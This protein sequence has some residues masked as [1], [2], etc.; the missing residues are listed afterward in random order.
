MS[1]FKKLLKTRG[2]PIELAQCAAVRLQAQYTAAALRGQAQCGPGVTLQ[3]KTSSP[4]SWS[5]TGISR[6]APT[7]LENLQWVVKD[8]SNW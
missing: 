5:Q 6:M 4:V 3:Q 7:A 2:S 8:L 1:Q